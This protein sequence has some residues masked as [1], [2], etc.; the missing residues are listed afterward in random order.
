MLV[1]QQQRLQDDIREIV[2]QHGHDRSALIPVLQELQKRHTTVSDFAMQVVAD[3]LGISPGRLSRHF[4]EETG[5][6][7]SDFL[8]DYRIERAKELL[9]LPDASIKQVSAACGYPDPN[10]FSRLFKKVTGLTPSNFS[11]GVKEAND[12]NG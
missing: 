12:E 7:F 5:K 3:E 11:S 10:Y 6:G 2:A 9:S 1:G 8:I 4:I